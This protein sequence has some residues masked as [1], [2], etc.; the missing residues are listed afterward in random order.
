M[1]DKEFQ[2]LFALIVVGFCLLYYMIWNV[3]R[4]LIA[5]GTDGKLRSFDRKAIWNVLRILV[6]RAKDGQFKKFPVVTEGLV[7][8]RSFRRPD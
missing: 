3:L 4:I 7:E 6:A 8:R 1:T 2:I 5:M